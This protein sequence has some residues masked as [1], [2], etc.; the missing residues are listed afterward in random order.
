MKLHTVTI[1]GPD[2]STAVMDLL[3]ISTAYPFVEWGILLSSSQ[4][5]RPG[6]PSAAWIASLE[7]LAR[8]GTRFSGQVG[9][10][11]V[12]VDMQSRVRSADGARLD[13]DKVRVCLE[14]AGQYVR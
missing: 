14:I 8:R 6:Y 10:A 12:W 5:P 9:D 1:S 4:V 13:L 11:P 7:P 3:A 2:N